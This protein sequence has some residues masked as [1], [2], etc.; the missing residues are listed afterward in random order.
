MLAENVFCLK[1]LS[2]SFFHLCAAFIAAILILL[3]C[4]V[5][6]AILFANCCSRLSLDLVSVLWFGKNTMLCYSYKDNVD[7][8]FYKHSSVFVISFISLILEHQRL[9]DLNLKC[10]ISLAHW[11]WNTPVDP[12]LAVVFLSLISMCKP[13]ATGF[14]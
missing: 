12:S 1:V 13:I 3:L 4:V 9:H 11:A 10:S 6:K 5:G 2:D 7:C 14:F 8:D